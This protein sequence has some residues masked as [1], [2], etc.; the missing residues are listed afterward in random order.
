M[1]NFAAPLQSAPAHLLRLVL[2]SD[3]ACRQRVVVVQIADGR[4]AHLARQ[5]GNRGDSR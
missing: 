5:L 2:R 1:A 3:M 4:A